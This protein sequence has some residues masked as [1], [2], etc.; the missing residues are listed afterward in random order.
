MAE[1]LTSRPRYSNRAAQVAGNLVENSN[2]DML[3]A[4]GTPDTANPVANQG[5]ANACPTLLSFAPWQACF[6]RNGKLQTF[7]W[8]YGNMLGSEETIASFTDA[9]DASG[10][11]TNKKVGMLFQNDADE[12]SW[13]DPSAAPLPPLSR[14]RTS[15][16]SR[17]RSFRG[18][19]VW[20]GAEAARGGCPA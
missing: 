15:R 4:S 19:R 18:E 3:L 8:A 6:I 11:A 12:Q 9:F 16:S 17:P 7:K 20:V 1:I 2:V 14:A 13:M 5:K 10:V